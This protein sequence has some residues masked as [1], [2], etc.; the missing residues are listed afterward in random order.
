M[1]PDEHAAW[2]AQQGQGGQPGAPA[3][4]GHGGGGHGGHGG[5][6]GEIELWAVQSSLFKVVVTEGSGRILYRNDR[7]STQPPA[8]T[9][10]DTTC[11]A[12]WEPLLLGQGEVIGLGVEQDKIGSVYRPDGS[13]QVTLAG[14]PLY[15]HAGEGAGQSSTAT[16]A[17]GVWFA[18]APTGEKAVRA[19]G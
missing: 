8:S 14:W 1:T 4:S 12:V 16:G 10:I 2:L 17:D 9:C 13:Q 19:E 3:P 7:D 15:T 18:I 5:A 6:P 11:T